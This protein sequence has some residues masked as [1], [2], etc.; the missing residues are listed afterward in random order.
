[1]APQNILFSATY[2]AIVID[3]IKHYVGDTETFLIQKEALKLKGVKNFKIML[4][5]EDKVDFIAKMHTMLV[6][7]MT[8]VF[9]N[10]KDSAV[11]LQ[12]KL[13]KD[14]IEAKILTG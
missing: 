2:N 6:T 7:A 13:K 10:Q 1:M 5:N 8:M 12:A 11:K 9:V 4:S 3:K 14:M